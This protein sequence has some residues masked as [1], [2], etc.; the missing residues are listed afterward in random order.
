MEFHLVILS[1]QRK[2]VG[3]TDIPNDVDDLSVSMVGSNQMELS[4]TPVT[5]LDIS[6]Y[7]VRFQDVQSGATWND[8]T[9]LAKVVRSKIKLF[10]SKCTNR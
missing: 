3:A 6:W 5:D 10:S 1:A 4:W 7:E 9:P 2:I 8:S